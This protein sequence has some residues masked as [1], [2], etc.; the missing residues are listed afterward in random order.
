[1][2]YVND[3][4]ESQKSVEL[5]NDIA[6]IEKEITFLQNLLAVKEFSSIKLLEIEILDANNNHT[7]IKKTIEQILKE[8]SDKIAKKK[9][10][11]A[12]KIIVQEEDLLYNLISKNIFT[13]FLYRKKQKV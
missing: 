2:F 11:D 5:K 8:T 4:K 9:D 3:P 1:M 7:P 6:A 12:K 13:I 10:F